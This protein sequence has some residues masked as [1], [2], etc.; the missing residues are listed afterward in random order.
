M[1]ACKR[2]RKCCTALGLSGLL[3]WT[4]LGEAWAA[5]VFVRRADTVLA[6]K[7]YRLDATIDYRLSEE[8]LQALHNGVPL[9]IRLD[10]EVDR[11]RD[12]WLSETVA[13]LQQRYELAYY[14]L[15]DQYLVRNINSGARYSF[16]TLEDALAQLG[17][18][19]DFPLLDKKFLRRSDVYTGRLRAQLDIDDLPT[20]LRLWAYVSA[21]WRLSSEWY[22]WPI[23]H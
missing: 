5:G 12:Y 1:R 15:A 8:V 11:S 23:Q 9:N 20:P 2:V 10:I 3:A 22:P 7:V 19:N 18:V 13:A 16:A 6:D 14:P 17:E 4:G 21:G